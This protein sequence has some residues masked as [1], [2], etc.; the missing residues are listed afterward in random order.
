MKKRQEEKYEAPQTKRTQV[1]LESGICASSANIRNP[2]NSNGKIE[3]H[4][5][6]TDFNFTFSDRDWDQL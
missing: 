2:D 1:S 3:E 4:Q 6:N 5:K